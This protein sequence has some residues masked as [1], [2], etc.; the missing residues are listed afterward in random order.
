[1]PAVSC[2]F[3]PSA[4]VDPYDFPTRQR[5]FAH[6]PR[7]TGWIRKYSSDF[8]LCCHDAIGSER[9]SAQPRTTA[10]GT[11]RISPRHYRVCAETSRPKSCS[12]FRAVRPMAAPART[13]FV[14]TSARLTVLA[15]AYLKSS[16]VSLS[17]SGSLK[18]GDAE[19]SS[20]TLLMLGCLAWFSAQLL[21]RMNAPRKAA[22]PHS[23][24]QLYSVFKEHF[25]T[26]LRS[27]SFRR[28][29]VPSPPGATFSSAVVIHPLR[30]YWSKR[31]QRRLCVYIAVH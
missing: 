12:Y 8:L 20:T 19:A 9:M 30:R 26:K 7:S 3:Y 4:R 31:L 5:N 14:S 17:A 27:A 11:T 2:K 28:T 15:V 16:S 18:Q 13:G 29:F 21:G 6:H 10:A 24:L 25:E 22:I 23:C 1:M